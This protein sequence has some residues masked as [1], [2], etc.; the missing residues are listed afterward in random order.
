MRVGIGPIESM[1]N[2]MMLYMC[3]I[4]GYLQLVKTYQTSHLRLC[5]V[6]NPTASGKEL[7]TLIDAWWKKINRFFGR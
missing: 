1:G 6:L 3:T 7:H 4:V 2:K 5:K